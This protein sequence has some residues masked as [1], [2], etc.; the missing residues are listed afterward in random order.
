MYPGRCEA[1]SELYAGHH[2][3]LCRS[4]RIM[5]GSLSDANVV[6]E[7]AARVW[8]ALVANDGKLLE[9]YKPERKALLITFMRLV[10]RDKIKCYIRSED[11]PATTRGLGGLSE[12]AGTNGHCEAISDSISD[13]LATLTPREQKFCH[14][15]LLQPSELDSI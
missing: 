13:F 8:Y 9:Q 5:L 1:W 7:I 3:R 6:D 15:F 10:V 14:E 12:S 4:I 11:S 2:D